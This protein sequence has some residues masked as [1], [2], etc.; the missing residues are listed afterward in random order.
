[1][2]LLLIRHAQ[3]A[4]QDDT[5]YPDDSERPLVPK[6]RRI[7]RRMSKALRRSKL[8]PD[9]VF[10]SPWKRAWQ[11]ARVVIEE[12]GLPKSARIAC[13]ALAAR[14]ELGALATE[15]GAIQQEETI[16]LV[17]HEP[18]LGELA[19]LLLTGKANGVSIDFPKSGVMGIEIAGLAPGAGPGTLR[20][21]LVP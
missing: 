2:L 21:F 5:R 16:A 9:R 11:T 14:P 7:Q 1:M 15:I 19:S 12:M 20:F 13:V 8:V 4:E 18:W 10:S 6:G 17:G 3:A